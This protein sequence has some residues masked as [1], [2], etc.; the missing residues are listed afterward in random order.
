MHQAFVNY[1]TR[2]PNKMRLCWVPSRK[3]HN[4][5]GAGCKLDMTQEPRAGK[6]PDRPTARR[7]EGT[8]TNRPEKKP[9]RQIDENLRRV[10]QQAMDEEIP[11]RLQ[12]LIEELRQQDRKP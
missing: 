2:E 3:G 9:T 1:D 12:A 6:P 5:Q 8:P 7:S 11:D 4:D 10:Y